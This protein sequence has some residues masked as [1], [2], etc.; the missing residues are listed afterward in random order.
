MDP[1]LRQGQTKYPFLVFQFVREEEIDVDLNLEDEALDE[2][3][4]NKLQK[5]YDAPTYEV[6]SNV[7]RALTGRKVTVPGSYRSHH[8]ANALK[9]S[10]KAN[11]GFLY[12]LEKSILFI[13]KPPTFIPLNEIG[14]VT[15][16][17]VGQSGGSSRTFDMK[18][19]MKSGNDIQFSSINREEYA[20]IEDYLKQ[21]KIKIKS[22]ANEDALMTYTD[23][24]ELDDED[25]DEEDETYDSRKKR[26]TDNGP[27][28]AAGG[29][30]EDE[31]RKLLFNERFSLN[32]ITLL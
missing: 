22:E 2:K 1:P 7:F 32:L 28:A 20:N 3:Y 13:P 27:T 19:N 23:L 11:E 24:A 26:R 12:P 25:E 5:H 18:F 29:D 14:I 17:R 30:E 21:K 16:S 10:M 4:E 31:S 9:C 6:V 8:G 15:F